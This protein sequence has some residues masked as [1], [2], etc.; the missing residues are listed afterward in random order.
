MNTYPA[1]IHCLRC[2]RPMPWPAQVRAPE[3]ASASEFDQWLSVVRYHSVLCPQCSGG[4]GSAR[5]AEAVA[6]TPHA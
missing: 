2:R 1:T 5:A 3:G 6:A 4:P